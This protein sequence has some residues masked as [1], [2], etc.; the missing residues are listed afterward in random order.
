MA[1]FSGKL[2]PEGLEA[3]KRLAADLSQRYGKKK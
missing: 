1:G 3:A 2:S